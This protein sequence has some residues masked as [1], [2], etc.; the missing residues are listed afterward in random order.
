MARRSLVGRRVD[1]AVKVAYTNAKAKV[2]MDTGTLR[3]S[4]TLNQSQNGFN[5]SFKTGNVNP[6]SKRPVRDYI[7]Y[8]ERYHENWW[9]NTVQT[10]FSEL[11][12]QTKGKVKKK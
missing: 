5:I 2:P 4:L 11:E 9:D 7:D 8:V 12:K 6:K 10:F 3:N 1:R